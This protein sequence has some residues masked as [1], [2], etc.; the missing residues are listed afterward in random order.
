MA[1]MMLVIGP[2]AEQNKQFTGQMKYLR[3]YGLETAPSVTTP[4]ADLEE[5]GIER[6]ISFGQMWDD[7]KW[8]QNPRAGCKAGL[9]SE[10]LR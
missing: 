10:M 8:A 4:H 7:N 9:T 1:K 3:A 5:A 6:K 2:D